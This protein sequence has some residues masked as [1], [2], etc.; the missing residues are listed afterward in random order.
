[1]Y[2]SRKIKK[3]E[4][5][6][7]SRKI[8][9][10]EEIV[11]KTIPYLFIDEDKKEELD[12]QLHVN[13]SNRC[14]DSIVTAIT[15]VLP[16]EGEPLEGGPLKGGL[17]ID[18]I[19]KISRQLLN[20]DQST[21]IG[22]R[23][24]LNT[25]PGNK[26]FKDIYKKTKLANDD[27]ENDENNE[28]EL[29]RLDSS[30]KPLLYAD[31]P[32]ID[33]IPEMF[34]S[35]ENDTDIKVFWSGWPEKSQ[36]VGAL[37]CQA[38]EEDSEISK[39]NIKA[40]IIETTAFSENFLE[41]CKE[42]IE[43]GHLILKAIEKLYQ[44][45]NFRKIYD[46]TR[47][48][49]FPDELQRAATS[50]FMEAFQKYVLNLPPRHPDIERLTVL[51]DS[52]SVPLRTGR[53]RRMSLEEFRTSQLR[54]SSPPL[55]NQFG[56]MLGFLART[57]ARVRGVARGSRSVS[58]VSPRRDPSQEMDKL[59]TKSSRGDRLARVMQATSL[60]SKKIEDETLFL[61]AIEEQGGVEVLKLFTI[62]NFI[63]K[64]LWDYISCKF[65]QHNSTDKNIYSLVVLPLDLDNLQGFLY[66]TFMQIE[67]PSMKC[68][69]I[70]VIFFN[71]NEESNNLEFYD[72]DNALNYIKNKLV[73][74]IEYKVIERLTF[75]DFN[76]TYKS[77]IQ[78]TLYLI[79]TKYQGN[80]ETYRLYSENI[81]KNE[82]NMKEAE[83]LDPPQKAMS[84]LRA[85]LRVPGSGKV[86]TGVMEPRTGVWDPGE[87][88]DVMAGGKFTR[89]NKIKKRRKTKR[90]NRKTKMRKQTK[91]FGKKGKRNKKTRVKK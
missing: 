5:M 71:Y 91:K 80:P 42:F 54:E 17:T 24:S 85:V 33:K 12:R 69:K 75:L 31:Y 74:G 58:E 34:S 14:I 48:K 76:P 19:M 26:A 3:F 38:I 7:D 4:E 41:H 78:E 55:D 23:P 86:I 39:K 35:V 77:E 68:K 18:I 56:G 9:E 63:R 25:Q 30:I 57:V 81:E 65:A 44:N 88:P 67:L 73:P 59:K 6:D 22:H 1:M 87:D 50:M 40:R 51:F 20:Q 66:K 79:H 43:E 47:I 10:F 36:R 21:G 52:I 8:K 89:K 83:W 49:N 16:L 70:A 37:I 64:Y 13:K 72:M 84:S 28:D 62:I 32:F 61:Q 15:N 45:P 82:I 27:D 2:D 11:S 53:A 90:K 60:K 29:L 46:S